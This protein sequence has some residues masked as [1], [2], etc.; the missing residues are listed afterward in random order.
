MIKWKKENPKLQI[1]NEEKPFRILSV[2]GGGLKGVFTVY[3]IYKLKEEYNIDLFDEFDMFIGTSTG[4]IIIA[5]IML[6]ADFKE[7][8][9]SYVEKPNKIFAKKNELLKQIN[10]LFLAR[11]DNTFFKE[12]LH[13]NLGNMTFEELDK[14][15]RKPYIFTATNIS[16]AKPIIFS[17]NHFS[18]INRRYMKMKIKDAVYSSSAAPLY[19]EPIVE[20]YTNDVIADGGIWAN[21]PSLTALIYA[22]GDLDIKIKQV[23][24]LSF[25]QTSTQNIKLKLDGGFKTIRSTQNNQASALFTS[26]IASRQNFDTLSSMI[27]LK[28]KLF[29][30][31]P[32][33]NLPGNKV[34]YIT[35]E[36]IEYAKQYWEENKE[37]LVKFIKEGKNLNYSDNHK[38]LYN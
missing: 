36:Y 7:M 17:S 27:I 26:S 34:D 19:F 32:E 30:Y 28:D 18:S 4:A 3:A 31:S 5:S 38:K 37:N 23:Q 6:R 12:E 9:Q 16:E 22:F 11:F 29:R 33:K 20:E 35:D 2:D 14:I 21:N 10:K 8:F 13:K 25:G 15:T 24:M 1:N